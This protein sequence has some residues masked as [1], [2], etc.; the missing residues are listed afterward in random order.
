MSNLI[1]MNPGLALTMV[2]NY[3]DNHLKVIN[4]SLSLAQLRTSVDGTLSPSDSRSV[5]FSLEDLKAFIKQIEKGVDTV[6]SG[7]TG[8]L[9]I[10]IYFAQYPEISSPLWNSND[11]SAELSSQIQY[12]GMETVILVPTYNDADGNDVDFDPYIADIDGNPSSLDVIFN[13][14]SGVLPNKIG[15]MNHGNLMPPPFVVSA[16]GGTQIEDYMG[17]TFMELADM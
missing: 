10:R 7:A 4:D 15:V 6:T 16:T 12:S 1:G 17:A 11:L 14:P 9:G 5:W 8:D 13:S 3:T 2:K